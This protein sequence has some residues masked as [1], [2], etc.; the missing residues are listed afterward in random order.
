MAAAATT[1]EIAATTAIQVSIEHTLRKPTDNKATS[2]QRPP[3]SRHFAASRPPSAP[4][5][6]YLVTCV[7]SEEPIDAAAPEPASSNEEQPP[8]RVT[9]YSEYVKRR[10]PAARPVDQSSMAMARYMFHDPLEEPIRH[11]LALAVERN[12]PGQRVSV[13]ILNRGGGDGPHR[14]RTHGGCAWRPEPSCLQTPPTAAGS[15]LRPADLI[16]SSRGV[17]TRAGRRRGMG[18]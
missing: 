7:S 6:P 14:Y 18:R 15:T 11:K 12:Q 5:Q 2:A 3:M 17:S 8:G 4:A 16:H 1:A 10:P 13:A 9:L